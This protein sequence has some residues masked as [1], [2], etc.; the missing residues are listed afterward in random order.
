MPSIQPPQMNKQL[1]TKT[2]EIYMAVLDAFPSACI[3]LKSLP[4]M[5]ILSFI[6]N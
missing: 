6:F 3:N 1:K 5:Y 2:D 4:Y